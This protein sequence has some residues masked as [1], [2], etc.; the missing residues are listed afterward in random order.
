MKESI[1]EILEVLEIW[2]HDDL[3]SGIGLVSLS[4]EAWDIIINSVKTNN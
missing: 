1:K 3:S 4:E 2:R